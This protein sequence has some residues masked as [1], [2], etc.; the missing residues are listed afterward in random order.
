MALRKPR[1]S[2]TERAFQIIECLV[3][4]GKPA[5]AYQIAKRL[6]A[7]LSTVYE[8]IAQ[9]E[10]LDILGRRGGD[11]E[12]FLGPRLYFYGLA[13]TRGL[14]Y[15]DVYRREAEAL[16]RDSGET[17][18]IC[19]RDG[20]SMVVSFMVDGSDQFNVSSRPGS[21]TPL[22]WSASG[23]LLIGHLSPE[24]RRAL[25]A[26][27]QP[28]P[29]GR[30][31]TNPKAL[32]KVC[33]EAWEQGYCIQIAESDFAVAC[34]AAPIVRHDG[35]CAATISLVVPESVAEERG[36]E[37]VAMAKA[38]ARKIEKSLGW[39][40]IA[41]ARPAGNEFPHRLRSPAAAKRRQAAG[42]GA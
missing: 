25:F 42:G 22:N 10:K 7:P 27:A 4:L 31:I 14:E 23:R 18:Q 24:E 33:R 13:Y 37:L 39:H 2:G 28:S 40:G 17:V 8:A 1:T 5:T 36:G 21:R 30:A 38:S 26:Q 32:E 3:E 20:D 6:G 15:E 16:S 34:I 11:G 9:L 12:F 19:I 29:T 35:V 41:G